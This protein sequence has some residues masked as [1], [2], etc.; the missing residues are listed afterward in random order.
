MQE[1]CLL[2]QVSGQEQEKSKSFPVP[3]TQSWRRPWRRS[4]RR[5]RHQEEVDC[6]SQ[7]WDETM[8]HLFDTQL[9]LSKSGRCKNICCICCIIAWLD[10]WLPVQTI[11]ISQ[12]NCKINTLTTPPPMVSRSP[13]FLLCRIHLIHFWNIYYIFFFVF[14]TMFL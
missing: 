9:C 2:E 11:S 1:S 4:S 14:A 6:P 13:V 5:S 7:R 3:T 10:L 8:N 12:K